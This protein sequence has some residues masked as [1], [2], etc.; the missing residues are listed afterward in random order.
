MAS[1]GMRFESV[2]QAMNWMDWM[3]TAMAAAN[4]TTQ[5]RKRF[6]ADMQA[7]IDTIGAS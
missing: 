5:D 1:V 2:E 6:I 3:Q 4:R 7:V